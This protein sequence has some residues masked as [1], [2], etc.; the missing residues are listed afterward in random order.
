MNMRIDGQTQPPDAD[1]ARRLESARTA[2]RPQGPGAARGAGSDRVEVSSD[3]EFVAEAIR[4]AGSAP[5]IRPEAV[6]RARQALA[7][8]SLGRDSSRLADAIIDALTQD[9]ASSE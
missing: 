9:S 8:G 3:A 7:D 4:A 2:E 1:A 5:D 6:E